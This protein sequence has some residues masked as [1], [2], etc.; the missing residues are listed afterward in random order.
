MDGHLTG[1]SC[2]WYRKSMY[3]LWQLHRLGCF[4]ES[5]IQRSFQAGKTYAFVGDKMLRND[6]NW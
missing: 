1:V 6:N 5:L 4:I 2:M 3:R